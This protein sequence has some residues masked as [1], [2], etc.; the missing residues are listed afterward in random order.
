MKLEMQCPFFKKN[1]G[2]IVKCEGGNLKFPDREARKDYLIC[3]CANN[4][5]WHKCTIS[6]NLE[7]YY[8]RKEKE[9][10]SFKRN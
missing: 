2:Q 5:H 1:E 6:K 8:D 4:V 7:N 3:Y 10:D 9:N